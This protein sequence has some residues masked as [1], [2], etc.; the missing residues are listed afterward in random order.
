LIVAGDLEREIAYFWELGITDFLFFTG[1]L[2]L[3]SS[4]VIFVA[5]KSRKF[6]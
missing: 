6:Y 2:S 4:F 1:V 3:Y 5:M